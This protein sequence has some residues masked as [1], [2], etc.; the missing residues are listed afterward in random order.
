MFRFILHQAKTRN[1]IIIFK[2]HQSKYVLKLFYFSINSN[3]FI[4]LA[5]VSLTFET[6]VQLGMQPQLHPYLL[7]IFFATL[8]DYNVHRLITVISNKEALNSQKHKW[9]KQHLYL[10]YLIVATSVIGFLWTVFYADKKV[11]ITLAPIALITLFYSVPVFKNKKNIFRLREI[12]C[13]KIFLISFVWSAS[14]IFLPVIQSARTFD[15]ANI[16]AM[17][18][19]RFLFV[20]A[21]TIP[22]DIRDMQADTRQGLKT[23]PL[24]I[25]KKKAM[26]LA[27]MALALFMTVCILHYNS[28]NLMWLN[29]AF[30]LSAVST[31][32][33]MNNKKLQTNQYYHYGILDGTLLLQG[34]FVLAGYFLH[35]IIL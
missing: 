16:L 15:K 19:E 28:F 26:M 31:L 18:V 27:N 32:F 10:F 9:V 2:L 11:L 17:L 7:L 34:L 25:G 24:L 22:F 4:S 6:Q 8:F 33:F 21:V 12:P 20:F 14:T 3:I 23:I 29:C 30:S 35:N 5:A 13:L 1:V